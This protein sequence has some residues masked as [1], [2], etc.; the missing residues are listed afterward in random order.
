[1]THTWRRRSS[2]KAPTRKARGRGRFSKEPYR[3]HIRRCDRCGEDVM[4]MA[5]AGSGKPCPLDLKRRPEAN[6]IVDGDV[7]RVLTAKSQPFTLD[8]ARSQGR[9]LFLNHLIV[10]QKEATDDHT[11]ATDSH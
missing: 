4:M 6:L 3:K 1:M 8:E 9:M 5:H 7:Y 10:C 11:S 2:L